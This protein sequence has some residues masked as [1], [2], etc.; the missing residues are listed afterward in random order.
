MQLKKLAA[1]AAIATVFTSPAAAEDWVKVDGRAQGVVELDRSRIGW[2]VGY[3]YSAIRVT[4]PTERRTSDG[5]HSYRVSEI[6]RFDRCRAGMAGVVDIRHLDAAG[7][8][9]EYTDARAEDLI[10]IEKGTASA[11]IAKIVCAVRQPTAEA[12]D[13]L[14]VEPND[15]GS[16]TLIGNGS[17]G[18]ISLET[19]TLER[20]EDTR[21]IAF[22]SREVLFEDVKLIGKKVRFVFHEKAVDCKSQTIFTFQDDFYDSRGR[23]LA[24]MRVDD[25]LIDRVFPGTDDELVYDAVCGTDIAKAVAA[26]DDGGVNVGTAWLGPKGYLVTAHHVV[27]D[28]KS[29]TLYQDGEAVGDATVVTTDPA[30]DIAVLKPNLKGRNY[31]N[32]SLRPAPPNLGEDV[33]TLG[34]P[35]PD[36]MG[37][38]IKMTSGE[39]S[40]LAGNDADSNRTD[41][42]RLMQISAPV[43]S[44]NSG[45]PVIDR[46]GRV[47]GIVISKQQMTGEGEIAQ[48]VNFALKIGYVRAILD[49]LPDLGVLRQARTSGTV[50]ELVADLRTGVFLISSEPLSETTAAK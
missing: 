15:R 40:S 1:L 23:H 21:L 11:E 45:G 24:S 12:A 38:A 3:V 25:A 37:Q 36:T 6:M 20:V 32:I 16:W 14:T 13:P 2:G 22:Y 30:N 50:P 43:Q 41:D 9:V 33:F 48:N 28:A 34:Y 19:T 8:M 29:V 18:R 7:N 39:I 5:K 27:G 47:V 46:S 35:S 31:S 17:L 49:D 42:R 10:K 4:H 44:G 26:E